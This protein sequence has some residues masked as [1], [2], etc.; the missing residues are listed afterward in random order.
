MTIE[1]PFII[2]AVILCLNIAFYVYA[3]L[4]INFKN[5]TTNS[6][7][8][9]ISIMVCA[10]NE[11]Q[12]LLEL[13]PL[14][15]Q[16]QYPSFEIILINDASTDDTLDVIET[17]AAQNSRV[18]VVDVV[19]NESFWGNKKYAM[20]LGIK[21]AIYKKHLFIDADCRPVSSKWL[22][23]MAS[24]LTGETQIVLGYSG[25]YS[26]KSLLNALIRYE[27]VLTAF[28]YMGYA[29]RGNPYMGVGRNMGYTNDLFYAVNGFV[30]HI[31]IMGGDDDL[32]VNQAAT[33]KNTAVQLDP[34]SFTMSTPKSTWKSWRLQKQ[35]HVNTAQYYK[36]KHK[37]QLGTFYFSQLAFF[38]TALAG[39]IFSTGWQLILAF[40]LLR[41]IVVWSIIGGVLSRFRE[42]K[43]IP[44]FPILE[45]ILITTQLA[46][47]LQS[48]K[49]TKRWK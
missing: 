9:P 32:F 23:L 47:F 11:A 27:T 31:K 1:L 7:K 38:I 16:Q 12:N 44:L 45:I 28:Q 15:L 3:S 10:K 39:I 14:L 48:G 36:L 6:K 42:S 20:T 8:E 24:Q 22:E 4:V 33:G 43:L 18:N 29:L 26:N 13:V 2:L 37:L 17:F 25:Y 49:P 34:E 30:N 35:R 46:L 40:V 21:K 41:Y 19:S 5:T